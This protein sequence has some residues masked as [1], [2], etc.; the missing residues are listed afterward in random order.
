MHVEDRIPLRKT[1]NKPLFSILLPFPCLLLWEGS[2][3]K[4]E[5]KSRW[6]VGNAWCPKKG[7]GATRLPTTQYSSPL[8]EARPCQNKKISVWNV[9]Y[10]LYL[11][12]VNLTQRANDHVCAEY[13]VNIGWLSFFQPIIWLRHDVFTI[14]SA[15]VW[16][17]A[18]CVSI[19]HDGKCASSCYLPQSYLTF[20]AWSIRSLKMTA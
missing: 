12:W 18:R 11:F 14:Y 16:L 17:D 8:N 13:I 19:S 4:E 7:T 1:Q 5:K 6:A 2:P 10:I 9:H 15:K 3:D 20:T